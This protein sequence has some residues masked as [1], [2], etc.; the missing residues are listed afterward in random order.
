VHVGSVDYLY[1]VFAG[2]EVFYGED[3]VGG[4]SAQYVG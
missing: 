1:A 2:D 3:F 4:E